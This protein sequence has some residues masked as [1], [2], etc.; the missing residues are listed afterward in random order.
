MQKFLMALTT[1]A[2]LAISGTAEAALILGSQSF[3][4]S[5]ITGAGSGNVPNGAPLASITSFGGLTLTTS[6]GLGANSGGFDAFADGTLF[7][8][9]PLD[10]ANL[11]GFTFSNAAFGNLTIS[12]AAT[13]SSTVFGQ[14]TRSFFFLGTFTPGSFFNP[15]PGNPVYDPTPVSFTITM[16]QSGTGGVISGSAT[17]SAPP[18]FNDVVMTPEP[19]SIAMFGTMLVPLALGAFRRRQKAAQAAL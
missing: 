1:T 10:T 11:L 12:D 15:D 9:S 2:F 8:V 18:A 16:N 7:A 19:A 3:S 6:S 13:T 5:G 14:V 4:L 17:L